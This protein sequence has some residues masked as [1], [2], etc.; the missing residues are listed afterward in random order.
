MDRIVLALRGDVFAG[1][2]VASRG[3]AD[4]ETVFVEQAK[5]TPSIFGST[6]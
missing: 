2:A 5:P 4:Q 1:F 6:T 3:G